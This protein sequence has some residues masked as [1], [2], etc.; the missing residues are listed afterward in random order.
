MNKTVMFFAV[1]ALLAPIMLSGAASAQTPDERPDDPV[2]AKVNGYEI[3]ASEV[4]LAAEDLLPQL[5]EQPAQNRYPLIVQYLIERHMLAQVA[6]QADITETDAFQLRMKFYRAKALRDAYFITNLRPTVTEDEAREVYEREAGNVGNDE[7]VRA[8]HI[9]VDD[10][11]T[12]RSLIEQLGGGADFGELAKQHSNDPGAQD[13]GDL[14]FFT[15]G[16]MV[17][18]FSDAAFALQPGQ[19][20]EPVQ[21]QFGWHVIKVEER[22]TPEARPFEELRDGLIQLLIQQ[23]VRDAVKELQ[24]QST[25]EIL[26]PDLQRLEQGGTVGTE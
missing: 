25:I 13:G 15:R 20:S 14:G 18:S 8:R 24:D 1:L 9:L 26:D 21:T 3:R 2:V 4:A 17:D 7:Q 12:A 22:R 16:E 5:R 6:A 23:R 19:I 11:A 10:E